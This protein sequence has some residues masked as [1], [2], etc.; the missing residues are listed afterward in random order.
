MAQPLVILGTHWLAEEIFDLVSDLPEYE[1]TAF[2]ENWDRARCDLEIEG[3]PVLWVED[4]AG[5]TETHL[6]MCALGTTQRR[7]LIEQVEG[8][9]MR[10]ATLVHPT[11]HVSSRATLSPG[12]FVGAQ[13]VIATRTHLE[14]H[15]FVNRGV[16]IGHHAR[17]GRYTSLLCGANVAGRVT[18]GESSYLG[19][20]AV[21]L[22]TLSIGSYSVVGAGAVV[23]KDVPD[24]VKVMG[25][26]ARIVETEIEGK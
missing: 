1:V 4:V 17:I 14:P 5:L 7:G 18:V 9:G 24:R 6:A 21:V 2:V 20:G 11:A 3:R 10:F 25:V 19:M 13:A 16:L 8:M 23:T 22:D 15:V 12:C 26:Q